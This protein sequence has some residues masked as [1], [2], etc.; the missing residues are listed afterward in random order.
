MDKGPGVQKMFDAIAHRYDL[1]NRVMTFGQDQRWRRFV[2]E[3]AGGH[4]NGWLLDLAA[5][6]GDIAALLKQTS[7]MS[8]VVGADFS[9]NMLDEAASRFNGIDIAWHVCDANHLPY[10]GETFRAV[11]FGFLLRNVDDSLTVLR[12]VRRIL[13]KGGK[14]VCLDTTPPKKTMSYPFVQLYLRY[15]IPLL[16][17]LIAHD[18]AAYSYLTGSTLDFHGADELAALFS[19][20]GFH[21]VRYKTF[22]LGTI[23]IHWGT[24]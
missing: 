19:E 3:Q 21:E 24:K 13:A 23:A 1:M 17:R 7:P 2:V 8:R 5:G 4:E 20:A 12:E 9:R 22:M 11:T 15:G 16:G 14:V 18:E 10:R 6:T